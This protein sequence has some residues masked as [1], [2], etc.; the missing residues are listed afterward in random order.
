MDSFR[1]L[2]EE[3]EEVEAPDEAFTQMSYLERLE[4]LFAHESWPMLEEE[5]RKKESQLIEAL[6]SETITDVSAISALRGR[7]REVRTLLAFRRDVQRA[8]ADLR[9]TLTAQEVTDE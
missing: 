2:L 5:Y 3:E 4:S 9:H 7:L 1:S 8:L 6:A